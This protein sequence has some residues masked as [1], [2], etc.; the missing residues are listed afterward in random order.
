MLCLT[1]IL[2]T[3]PC[4][5]RYP[6]D[7]NPLGANYSVSFYAAEQETP[8]ITVAL[9]WL[10]GRDS[11]VSRQYAYIAIPKTNECSTIPYVARVPCCLMK[12]QQALSLTRNGWQSLNGSLPKSNS[13]PY[14]IVDGTWN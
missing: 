12:L 13:T 7:M 9:V 8:G 3:S 14:G 4:G 11:M 1:V 2:R 5:S 6:K 10:V